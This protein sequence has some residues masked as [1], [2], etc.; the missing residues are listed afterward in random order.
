MHL[1]EYS[2]ESL[3]FSG[4]GVSSQTPAMAADALAT[5]LNRW[6]S[7]HTGRRLLQI[8]PLP[9]AVPQGTGLAVLLVHTAGSELTGELA[10][11][12]AAAV[13]DA[14]EMAAVDEGAEPG[15]GINGQERR[16]PIV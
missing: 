4:L 9:A 16:R 13:D 6:A 1:S 7:E 2:V 12:V 15:V 11:Q 10:E 8:T 3:S 14:L 5:A